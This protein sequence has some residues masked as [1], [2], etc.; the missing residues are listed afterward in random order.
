MKGNINVITANLG[1]SNA[2]GKRTIESREKMSRAAIK[3]GL[4]LGQQ[5]NFHGGSLGNYYEKLLQPLGY[6]REHIVYWGRRGG[7]GGEQYRL[8]FALIAEKIDIEIDGPTHRRR[9]LKDAKRDYVLTALGWK[10]IR[11]KEC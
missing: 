3:R 11:V 5:F 4:R 7:R 1:N 9:Q 2:A 6:V 10:V 8:D